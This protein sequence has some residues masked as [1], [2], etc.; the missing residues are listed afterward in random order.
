MFKY[1]YYLVLLIFIISCD[2]N[3]SSKN[4]ANETIDSE[5]LIGF[6]FF[7]ELKDL[8]PVGGNDDVILPSEIEL[9]ETNEAR[10]IIYTGTVYQEV[11]TTWNFD[12]E[13]NTLDIGD[14]QLYIS[15]V[16]TELNSTEMIIQFDSGTV[17]Y[18]KPS[19]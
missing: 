17:V 8:S 18:S 2:D 11:E 10:L 6:W 14:D 16:V 5:Q 1:S 12:T 15:G 9:V 13:T 19:N 4:S 3:D 7:Q